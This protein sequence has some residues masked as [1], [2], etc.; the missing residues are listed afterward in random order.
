MGWNAF[1]LQHHS[2]LWRW[3]TTFQLYPQ[4]CTQRA[5]DLSP[6]S[7]IPIPAYDMHAYLINLTWY[8]NWLQGATV[9]FHFELT[10]WGMY[11]NGVNQYCANVVA[12]CVLVSP[13]PQVVIPKKWKVLHMIYPLEYPTKRTHIAWGITTATFSFNGK[14]MLTT[15][16]TYQQCYYFSPLAC[17]NT[18]FSFDVFM[19]Q[20][21]TIFA[22][23]FP[24]THTFLNHTLHVH[25]CLTYPVI[26]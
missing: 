18:T 20:N 21:L 5:A 12:I 25:S 8:H 11:R 10:H 23:L 16:T 17:T 6:S 7:V 3:E 9:E 15:C 2:A 26:P 4:L 13:K 22:L 19:P 14:L 24:Y 1:S